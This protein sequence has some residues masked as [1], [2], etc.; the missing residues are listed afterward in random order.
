[1]S[2]G[3]DAGDADMTTSLSRIFDFYVIS[4]LHAVDTEV[5]P[6]QQNSRHI[7]LRV[8]LPRQMTMN[9]LK[10]PIFPKSEESQQPNN[11]NHDLRSQ[12]MKLLTQAASS[13]RCKRLKNHA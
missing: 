4:K 1:V 13:T 8:V 5:D 6:P 7:R 9:L 10:A 11:G 12:L 2:S 3:T